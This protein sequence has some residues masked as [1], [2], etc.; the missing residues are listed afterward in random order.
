MSDRIETYDLREPPRI[1]IATVAGDIIIKPWNKMQAKVVLSGDADTV[2]STRIDASA[3]SLSIRSDPNR[4]S[5]RWFAKAMDVIV[6][7]PE[8]GT[9]RIDSSSGD[10]R[11]RVALEDVDIASA[12]GSV[13]VDEPIGD[14]RIKVAS[15]DVRVDQVRR[16]I[17][18]SSA[19]GDIRIGVARDVV[20]STASGSTRL[21]TVEAS[22]RI[23]SASGDVRV[24]DFMGSDLTIKT[25]SGN[26]T[27]GLAPGRVVAAEIK[28]MSGEFRN[29][30]AAT[31]GPKH[32]RMTLTVTSF[33]G[34]V[35]L[36]NAR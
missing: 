36:R 5:R 22:A 17:E 35:T 32:G 12:S 18:V 28:T 8:G 16:D 2:A 26:A 29:K 1:D 11:I 20:L 3:D 10:I 7:T 34:D 14:A 27:I 33:S 4:R 24:R 9:L 13:R 25:M 31:D 21:G 6:S 30:I 15:G 23:R 19:N